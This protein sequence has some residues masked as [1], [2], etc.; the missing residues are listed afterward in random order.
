MNKKN[1]CSRREA[2]AR[3]VKIAALAAGLGATRTR[4]L[5]AQTFRAQTGPDVT[6]LIGTKAL[7]RNVKG[8]K[9]LLMPKSRQAEVFSSEFGRSPVFQKTARGGKGFA[10][11][12]YIGNSG[13]CSNLDCGIHVCNGETCPYYGNWGP[14]D[15]SF[16]AVFGGPECPSRCDT[17]CGTECKA[18][19]KPCWFNKKHINLGEVKSNWLREVKGDPFIQALYREFNQTTPEGLEAQL[20]ALLNKRR[21]GF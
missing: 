5:V 15:L 7:D 1:D 4:R 14:D 13:S 18:N 21:Q 16:E 2:L 12:D 8:L 9:I 20:V 17:Y 6:K 3:L 19:G 10:C 11:R